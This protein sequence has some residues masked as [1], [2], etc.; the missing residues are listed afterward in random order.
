MKALH[1][2]ANALCRELGAGNGRLALA[3]CDGFGIPDHLL[4]ARAAA[5]WDCWLRLCCC[6]LC[7]GAAARVCNST[8]G[9]TCCAW[10]VQL[11]CDLLANNGLVMWNNAL[12]CAQAPIAVGNWRTFEG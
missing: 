4:Q 11:M 5:G 8:S 2:K 9:T 12:L 3:L 1:A 10:A 7:G 6:G